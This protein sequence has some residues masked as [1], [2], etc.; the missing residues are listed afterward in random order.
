MRTRAPS[1]EHGNTEHASTEHGNTGR[2][3]GRVRARLRDDRGTVTA[4]LLIATPLLF[5]LVLSVVQ[6][7]LFEYAAHVAEAAAQQGLAASR[8]TGGTT[9]AGDTA[10]HALLGQIGSAVLSNEAVAT[11]RGAIT[12]TVTVSGDAEAVLPFFSLPVSV[13]ASGVTEVFTPGSTQLSN[14]GLATAGGGP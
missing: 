12:T 13:A 6:F 4:E 10:A 8:V 7:A 14:A 3:R 11:T 2:W 5:L 1:T 9:D